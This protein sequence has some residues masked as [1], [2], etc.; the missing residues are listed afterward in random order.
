M[1]KSER[2]YYEKYAAGCMNGSKPSCSC[3]CPFN[4]EVGL[5]VDKM[6]IHSY[7]GAYR[8]YQENVVFPEI[9]S[10]ICPAPCQAH[11]VFGEDAIRLPL[12]ERTCVANVREKKPS[13]YNMPAKSAGIAIVG[14]GLSGLAC[15]LKLCMKN[16]P[17]TVFEKSDRIGGNLWNLMDSEVFLAEFETQ[18]EDFTYELSLNTEITDLDALKE[19]D[20]VYIA[21]GPGGAD[22][23]LT[24]G[25]DRKS[26][27]SL[28]PGIFLGGRLVGGGDMDA[29][30]HGK[31]A[32]FSIEKYLK[33]GK[34]DGVDST[35]HVDT[36]LFDPPKAARKGGG[37][38][39]EPAGGE[40]YSRE[41]ASAEAKRCLKCDCSACYDRCELM[42]SIR[43]YPV[44]M[45]K[46]AVVS[47]FP[48]A[49]LD[50]KRISTRVIGTCLQCGACR[51]FCPKD[52]D[53][54][55]FF[56]DFRNKMVQDGTFPLPFHD[57]FLQDLA[58]SEGDD[59]RLAKGA[60]DGKTGEYAFFPGCQLGGTNPEA[61]KKTY[62]FLLEK[63]PGTSLLLTCC[64]VPAHWGGQAEQFQEHLGRIRR[65]WESLGKPTLI[66][67]CLTCQKTFE[68]FLPE[69]GV[70]SLYALLAGF[71]FPAS[72][73][74][75]EAAVFDPCSSRKK[76]EIQESVRRLARKAGC[77]LTELENRGEEAE[78]CGHGGHTH[79]T[80]PGYTDAIAE[81]RVK[82]AEA[83]YLVYCA[84]CRETFADKGKECRHILDVIL[85]VETRTDAV[86]KSDRRQNRRQLKADLLQVFWGEEPEPVFS[87]YSRLLIGEALREKL[88]KN[89]I[90]ADDLLAAIQQTEESGRVVCDPEANIRVAH[91]RVGDRTYW[92]V[93]TRDENGCYE[94]KNAYSHRLNIEE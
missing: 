33:I 3:A 5:F 80:R 58:F 70:V 90:V 89:Y 16:Y 6:R 36:C 40:L 50:G 35:Y 41:E 29:I 10:R 7:S 4:L 19:F 54:E 31:I 84:N 14:A 69:I 64:G 82:Q 60:P 38:P 94:L 56:S 1:N 87:P 39:I 37:R 44:K 24:E 15:A 61:V 62:S 28:R 79:L 26:H 48:I 65:D 66:L 17:V 11:C 91:L 34:M 74:G 77:T 9:V 75:G 42:Q 2:D 55:K 81:K 85:G 53:M 73:A 63:F 76:P 71:D 23:G 88:T 59:V 18:F 43:Q 57:F 27:G 67:A 45:V 78:C 46:D 13:F 12:L 32:S 93:Y 49:G 22:F 30:E 52:I 21:T 47:L 8:L 92:A 51:D 72:A 86:T 20:A 68:S 83:P 25:M